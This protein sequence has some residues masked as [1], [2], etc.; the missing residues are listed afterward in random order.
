MFTKKAERP[1]FFKVFLGYDLPSSNFSGRPYYN[2][3][4][5]YINPKLNVE[6]THDLGLL[7]LDKEVNTTA[8]QSVVNNICLPKKFNG[9]YTKRE[10][11]AMIGGFGG[12]TR[13]L[14]TAYMKILN[15]KSESFAK[16]TTLDNQT[17]CKVTEKT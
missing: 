11:Y 8:N 6:L 9:W 7:K 15:Q 4:E 12:P 3:T 2:V 14:K 1:E 13:I 17:I 10:E 5:V 16:I